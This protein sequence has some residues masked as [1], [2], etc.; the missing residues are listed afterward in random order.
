MVEEEIA[1]KVLEG[2][3]LN[4][5]NIGILLSDLE[6]VDAADKLMAVPLAERALRLLIETEQLVEAYHNQAAAVQP[7]F[8][9]L[10]SIK[11]PELAQRLKVQLS[12]FGLN[13]Q[14]LREKIV[15]SARELA[16]AEDNKTSSRTSE[17]NEDFSEERGDDYE[18]ANKYMSSLAGQLERLNQLINLE[19]LQQ[20]PGESRRAWRER[21]AG[22]QSVLDSVHQALTNFRLDILH[23][24][25]W[26]VM[27]IL[28]GIRRDGYNRVLDGYNQVVQGWI[29]AL[30]NIRVN[31]GADDEG[32]EASVE[33]KATLAQVGELA[34]RVFQ[35][36]DRM[37]AVSMRTWQTDNAA[38]LRGQIQ[39]IGLLVQQYR[40]EAGN[41]QRRIYFIPERDWRDQAIARHTGIQLVLGDAENQLAK[42]RKIADDLDAPSS[43]PSPPEANA[44]SLQRELE[45]FETQFSNIESVQEYT[46]TIDSNPLADDFKQLSDHLNALKRLGLEGARYQE[47]EMRVMRLRYLVTKVSIIYNIERFEGNDDGPQKLDEYQVVVINRLDKELTSLVGQIPSDKR[48]AFQADLVRFKKEY[49]LLLGSYMAFKSV[50]DHVIGTSGSASAVVSM[51]L[52]TSKPIYF[53]IDNDAL[54]DL[55]HPHK[56]PTAEPELRSPFEKEVNPVIGVRRARYFDPEQGRFVERDVELTAFGQIMRY[57]DDLFSGR[58]PSFEADRRVIY[59]KKMSEIHNVIL[60][61]EAKRLDA[62]YQEDVARARRSGGTLPDRADGKYQSKITE[63]MVRRVFNMFVAM[64][65]HF[66]LA[67]SS[68]N[69]S[70]PGYYA[71]QLN[72]AIDE[73]RRSTG[74]LSALVVFGLFGYSSPLRRTEENPDGVEF[75]LDHLSPNRKLNSPGFSGK[76]IDLLVGA[77]RPNNIREK[78]QRRLR[79]NPHLAQ[80]EYLAD[81]PL[82]PL[83]PVGTAPKFN[84][85]SGKYEGEKYHYLTFQGPLQTMVARDP[86]GVPYKMQDSGGNFYN[87][88][89]P[90]FDFEHLVDERERERAQAMSIDEY[91]AY[92]VSNGRYPNPNGPLLYEIMPFSAEVVEE[93]LRDWMDQAKNI[94][95]FYTDIMFAKTEEFIK[96]SGQTLFAKLTKEQK[97]ALRLLEPYAHILRLGDGD[98]IVM[99]NKMML[100]LMFIQGLLKATIG[101]E[102]IEHIAHTLESYPIEE[103][104]SVHAVIE[105]LKAAVELLTITRKTATTFAEQVINSVKLD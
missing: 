17:D 38:E 23:M 56:L 82:L 48:A 91:E 9:S 6:R 55:L 74:G 62:V 30:A 49:G 15:K 68:F 44:E 21:V 14:E 93:Q 31:L 71:F 70:A 40:T 29:D 46:I 52:P 105:A 89:Q 60:G 67:P 35:L 19:Q 4:A 77:T 22:A 3:K 83:M 102:S 57:M 94:H 54:A 95:N 80:Y 32:A 24:R 41:L 69:Q 26:L 58:V 88:N 8:L 37:A 7:E 5:K 36:Q 47:L 53:G 90:Y 72:Y 84:K 28:D 75:L 97:Y 76:L 79:S 65:R 73:I 85:N 51:S 1:S 61:L 34:E 16:I 92:Y 18:S 99:R 86:N 100:S 78:V 43:P 10:R 11:L 50:K 27:N 45:L 64:C 13:E 39:Q 25:A 66:T 20:R 87:E 12:R 81:L 33:T 98:Q 96:M 59:Q 103:H 2:A 104:E 63:R 101:G 42:L